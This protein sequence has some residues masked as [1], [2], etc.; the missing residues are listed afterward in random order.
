MGYVK[1]MIIL[2]LLLN[3]IYTDKKMLFLCGTVANIRGLFL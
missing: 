2:I 3:I 1:Y